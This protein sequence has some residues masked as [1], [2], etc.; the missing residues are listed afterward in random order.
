[1]KKRL[2]TVGFKPLKSVYFEIF[3]KV[4]AVDLLCKVFFQ[5][6][7]IHKALDQSR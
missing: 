2:K 5:K 3:A 7:C 6:P 1:M 4:L